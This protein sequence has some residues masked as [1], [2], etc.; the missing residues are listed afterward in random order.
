MVDIESI[1]EQIKNILHEQIEQ[2][3][4]KVYFHNP[5]NI[6]FIWIDG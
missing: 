6:A 4:L 3:G 5:D 1:I 2:K